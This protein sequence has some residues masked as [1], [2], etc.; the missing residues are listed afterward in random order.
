MYRIAQVLLQEALNG[1]SQKFKSV[2]YDKHNYLNGSLCLIGPF[3]PG[4]F[5]NNMILV[6][7]KHMATFRS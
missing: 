5:Y 3:A 2:I 1:I 7:S 6:S 4:T